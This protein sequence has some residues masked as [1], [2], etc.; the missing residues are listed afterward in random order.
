MQAHC[1]FQSSGYR[2]LCT[3][4]LTLFPRGEGRSVKLY[5]AVVASCHGTEISESTAGL[6]DQIGDG[7]D[8]R[9]LPLPQWQEH[10]NTKNIYHEA[11]AG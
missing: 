3:P 8:H 4:R 2:A 7:L 9:P 1:S 5:G 6:P 11:Q 10:S